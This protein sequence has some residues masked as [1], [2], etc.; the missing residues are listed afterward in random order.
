[1]QLNSVFKKIKQIKVLSGD[2]GARSNPVMLIVS[3]FAGEQGIV[4]SY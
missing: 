4:I 2:L 3:V 1:M